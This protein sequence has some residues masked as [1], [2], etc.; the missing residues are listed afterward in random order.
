MDVKARQ[1]ATLYRG[2][3]RY[4]C[5]QALLRTFQSE[6]GVSDTAVQAASRIGSGRAEGG[7]CGALH[8]AGVLLNDPGLLER[9]EREFAG[10]AGSTRCRA[11]RALGRITCRECV[12]LSAGLVQPHMTRTRPGD[13]GFEEDLRDRE[14]AMREVRNRAACRRL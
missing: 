12:S 14:A 8:A 9:V 7:V 10:V 13:P 11:I 6:A 5:A 1:A 2:R 4:N 3:D